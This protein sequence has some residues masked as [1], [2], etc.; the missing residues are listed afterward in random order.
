VAPSGSDGKGKLA[1]LLSGVRIVD[2]T[3]MLAGPYGSML[4]ADL[5]A[6]VI[7]IEDPQG[8]DPTRRI[9]PPFVQGESGYF[10]GV[11]RNKR[12]VALDLRRA[13][14][15]QVLYDLVKVSD[16][17]FNNFRPGTMERLCCSHETLS[18][19]NPRI[20]YCSLT[21]FGETGP[22]R[23]RPAFDVA[24]QAVSGA[25]SITG[26][27]GR[28]P[29]RMG[30][31]MGDLSGSLFCAFAISA[32]LYARDKTGNG[33]YL[34]VSL[35]D[36]MVSLLTYVGQ[37]HLIDGKVPGPIGSAHQSVVPYRAFATKDIY[38]VVAVFVDKFWRAFCEVLGIDEL[39]EDP[40]FVDNDQRRE[41]REEL[42]D[43]LERIF[44][45]K[46]GDAWVKLLSEA[47][48]PCS[49][50]N[51]LD[52]VFS[53]PPVAARDMLVQTEHPRA[54]RIRSIGNPVKMEPPGE[55]RSAPAPLLGQHT[56]EVLREVLKYT[57]K[58]ILELRN[59]GVIA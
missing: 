26:E 43:I 53:E 49:P 46:S 17:V 24:I 38:I 55:Q 41:H 20:I 9:G 4:L 59:E 14:G 31:P 33:R 56:D 45:T 52:R 29:V 18:Q 13:E 5:G 25:M 58:R 21:G 37:Y 57:P 40:R 1:D 32:A 8:G 19:I 2:L 11:N 3:R 54:G 12:S 36:C 23:D 10:M 44:V 50:I 6:E 47:G 27:P 30:V 51:T 35:M 39:A 7:K 48:V 16:V 28:P 15:R 42:D 34:D 22:C